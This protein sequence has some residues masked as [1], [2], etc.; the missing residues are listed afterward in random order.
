M[1]KLIAIAS[2]LAL[3]AAPSAWAEDEEI[4]EGKDT[5][6]FVSI[7]EEHIENKTDNKGAN[8]KA[9]IDR[10]N[11]DLTETGLWRVM[12]MKDMADAIKKNGQMGL[13]AG[14]EALDNFETPAWMLKLVISTYGVV[15]GQTGGDLL[16]GA[17]ASTKMAR[18][19]LILRVVDQKGETLKSKNIDSG[20]I[21]VTVAA[22][23]Q[24]N[25]REQALQE[26]NKVACRQVVAALIEMTPFYIGDVENG[27]VSIDITKP[28][29][30]VGQE[31]RVMKRG[32]ARKNK[33]TGKVTKSESEVARIKVI[34][35]QEDTSNAKILDGKIEPGD[36][37]ED[38]YKDYFVRFPD[39]DQ[40]AANTPTPPPAAA[41]TPGK[42]KRF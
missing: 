38:P 22:G 23:V 1:K 16:T 28:T 30:Q 41:P 39:P 17:S 8:F 3:L 35:C 29:V 12:S 27:I 7:D 10:L 2:A 13:A 9:M 24:S 11:N 5:R 34:S 14:A 33:R 4:E 19:E 26:A 15:E 21:P 31:L 25:A 36:D 42:K 37:E 6:P 32:K 18:I 40:D 20:F